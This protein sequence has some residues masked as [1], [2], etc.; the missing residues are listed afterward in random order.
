MTTLFYFLRL[1]FTFVF[2]IHFNHK[3]GD[4][5]S[6]KSHIWYGLLCVVLG[7]ML[8]ACASTAPSTEA[9]AAEVPAESPAEADAEATDAPAEEAAPVASGRTWINVCEEE[10]VDGGEI[11]LAIPNDAMVG[12]TWLS[13][14]S[15]NES[16][17]FNQLTDLRY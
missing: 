10:P 2:H 4:E 3:E 11:T 13:F 5:M 17:M 6:M 9:P 1:Y 8:T 12:R 15:T 16:F 7:L 14:G